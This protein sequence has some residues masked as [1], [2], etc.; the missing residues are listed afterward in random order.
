MFYLYIYIEFETIAHPS[1]NTYLINKEMVPQKVY[2]TICFRKEK[3]ESI[4]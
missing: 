4:S 2:A 1:Y 3:K